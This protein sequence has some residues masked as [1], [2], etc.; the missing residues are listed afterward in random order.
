MASISDIQGAPFTLIQK[1]QEDIDLDLSLLDEKELARYNRYLN[2]NKR[3][4]FLAGRC[5][6]KRELAE[7]L[8]TAPADII[9]SIS[10]N[11]KPYYQKAGNEQIHFNLSHGSGFYILA[12]SSNPIGV[13]LEKK[14]EV[15][16]DVMQPILADQEAAQLAKL[17]DGERS[18][19][20]LKLFTAKEAFIKATDKRYGL[21]EITFTLSNGSWNLTSPECKVEFHHVDHENLEIAISID[22]G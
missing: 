2:T 6:I 1:S 18:D 9:L 7:T 4:E 11:G 21:D 17:P 8:G 14:R 22:L 19:Q 10:D 12:L 13:D 16:F 5:L 20:I 15:S 3:D